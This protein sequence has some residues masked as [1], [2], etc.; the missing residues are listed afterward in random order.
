M[1]LKLTQ[2]R[3]LI[4][5]E[6]ENMNYAQQKEGEKPSMS[7]VIMHANSLNIPD[8]AKNYIINYI[9][10]YCTEIKDGE[11]MYPNQPGK[12]STGMGWDEHLV[13]LAVILGEPGVTSYKQFNTLP[14]EQQEYILRDSPSAKIWEQF[15]TE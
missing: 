10:K 13:K 15:F 1:K 8:V 2:L 7:N 14:E 3:R 9:A 4:R 12:F 11:W 6:V 5:E